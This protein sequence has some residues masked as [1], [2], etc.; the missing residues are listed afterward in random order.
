MKLSLVSLDAVSDFSVCLQFTESSV[1][2]LPSGLPG[3]KAAS[4]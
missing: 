4:D 3:G 2:D 1:Q